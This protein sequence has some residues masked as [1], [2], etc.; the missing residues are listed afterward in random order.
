MSEARFTGERL[1]Q[2]DAL[3]ALDLARHVAAYEIARERAG[4][5][6]V[7]DLGS[8]SGYGTDPSTLVTSPATVT[9]GFP[10]I[11]LTT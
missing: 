1:H 11:L 2:G 5:G 9:R 3:F 6:R 7:L 8:G 4:G 10:Q